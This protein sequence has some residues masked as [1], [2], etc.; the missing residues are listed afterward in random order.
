MKQWVVV[1]LGV[2]ALSVGASA[3]TLIVEAIRPGSIAPLSPPTPRSGETERQHQPNA[4]DE[5]QD[6]QPAQ[7]G[8]TYG[9]L[10]QI[11]QPPNQNPV[12]AKPEEK[13]HWNTPEGWTAGFTGALFV[14]TTG[15][16]FFTGFLWWTTR[17]A[18]IDGEKALKV[19]Q[20]NAKAARDS[21]DA[22]PR[23]ER[24]YVFLEIDPDF[25]KSIKSILDDHQLKDEGL[26][27]GASTTATVKYQFVNHGKTPAVIKSMS[28]EFHHWTK[29]PEEI[30]YIDN[31]MIGEIV[32]RASEIWPPAK[33]E[34]KKHIFE[35]QGVSGVPD[36]YFFQKQLPLLDG[37]D[38]EAARSLRHPHSFLWFY[39]H[40]VYDDVFGTEHETRFCWY[41]NGLANSF[42]RYDRRPGEDLNRRT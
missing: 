25:P 35:E 12:A 19:A 2:M 37:I 17:R 32:I 30:R 33:P 14:A 31:Q 18:V 23:L 1:V 3:P 16:W 38:S 5:H 20:S 4:A 29:L 41:Y 26:K 15:L 6:T 8:P 39:G 34:T 13:S 28:A 24:A 9:V 10:I 40:I 22:L 21:A 11:Q 27:D 36:F 42:Q 7:T